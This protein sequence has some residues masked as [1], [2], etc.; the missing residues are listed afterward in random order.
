MTQCFTH[1]H[2][3]SFCCCHN[4]YHVRVDSFTFPTYIF[5]V[6]PDHFDHKPV[7]VSSAA[8]GSMFKEPNCSLLG[9]W[10]CEWG[11]YLSTACLEPLPPTHKRA[12]DGLMPRNHIY[13]T[14]YPSLPERKRFGTKVWS[15]VKC[16][17]TN[18]IV[19]KLCC[20]LARCWENHIYHGKI[21]ISPFN[22]KVK[23]VIL[24]SL[25]YFC[26]SL[27][28]NIIKLISFLQVLV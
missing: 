19:D 5:K 6:F 2:T 22:A 27:C 18:E 9:T 16:T 21:Y 25:F 20:I 17:K 24:N 13:S 8:A 1:N 28:I 4:N 12:K 23:L 15:V 14:H 11:W 3:S 7:L 10:F 26:V